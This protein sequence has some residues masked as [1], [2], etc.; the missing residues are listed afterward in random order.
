MGFKGTIDEIKLWRSAL[1]KDEVKQAMDGKL[2][3]LAVLTGNALTAW[4]YIK[5]S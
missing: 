5:K 2:S 3:K 1:T 4:G